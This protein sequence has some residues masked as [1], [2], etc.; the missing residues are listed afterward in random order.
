MRTALSLSLLVACSDGVIAPD[1]DGDGLSDALEI[2]LGLQPRVP[3]SDADGLA[4]GDELGRGTDPLRADTDGDGL[5]DG[6]ESTTDPLDSDVDDDGYP[7]GVE[8]ARGSDPTDPTSIVY[9]GGWPAFAKVDDLEEPLSER[10]GFGERIRRFVLQDQHGQDVDLYDWF[11]A[12]ETDVVLIL[13]VAPNCPACRAMGE[14]MS[15]TAYEVP[16]LPYDPVRKGIAV[17]ATRLVV[18]VTAPSESTPAIPADLLVWE[19]L[20]GI[21]GVPVL[22]DADGA[23]AS[24]AEV[25]QRPAVMGLNDQLEVIAYEP[26]VPE[27]ALNQALFQLGTYVYEYPY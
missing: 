17:G 6:D 20:F 22:L 15:N 1:A 2:R 8:V 10:W 23:L 27:V 11:T 3:D 9:Q 25:Q 14:W 13:V 16:G 24:Y 12:D 19:G 21:D 7:D 26:T 4:D 18:V 5:T